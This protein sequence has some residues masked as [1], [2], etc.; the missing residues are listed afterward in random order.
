MTIY[1]ELLKRVSEG[2]KYYVNLESKSMKIGNHY[3]IKDGVI[4]TE[5]DLIDIFEN[6][7]IKLEE[8]YLDY[9]YSLPTEKSSRRRTYYFKALSDEEMTDLEM[10]CAGNRDYT[11]A[12]LEGFLLCS[13]LKG[14]ITW[15]DEKKWFWQ[16]ENHP[17][18]VV[19]KKWF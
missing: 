1:E 2:E 13:I 9:R 3:D 5:Q 17:D 8:L 14:T 15:S 7:W 19:L 12:A 10:M 18:L 4:A 6:P 11:Q 16:S